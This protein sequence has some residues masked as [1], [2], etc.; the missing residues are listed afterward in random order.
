MKTICLIT[1]F[2]FLLAAAIS[3]ADSPIDKGSAIVG[4]SAF[5]SIESAEGSSLTTVSIMPTFGYFVSPGLMLGGTVSLLSMSTSGAS[6]TAFGIGP[7]MRYYF[8]ANKIDQ[9]IKGSMYPFLGGFISFVGE[10][11]GDDN[12]TQFGAVVGFNQMM[13]EQLSTEFQFRIFRSL[14]KSYGYD[15]NTTTLYFGVGITG[16]LY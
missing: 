11:G 15:F 1:L 14:Q 16:F 5:L 12:I 10:S 8:N 3:A 2:V 13:S 6:A 9:Y 7:E 4:G